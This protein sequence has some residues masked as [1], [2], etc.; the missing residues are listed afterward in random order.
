MIFA[1]GFAA[2]FALLQVRWGVDFARARA[3]A[4]DPP[5]PCACDVR[6]RCTCRW[7]TSWRTLS[8][9]SIPT[10]LHHARRAAR[11][12][13][14]SCADKHLCT[15]NTYT[16]PGPCWRRGG[17]ASVCYPPVTLLPLAPLCSQD[18]RGSSAHRPIWYAA[19]ETQ[20]R[21]CGAQGTRLHTRVRVCVRACER[22]CVRV[23]VRT[24]EQAS[25]RA[26]MHAWSVGHSVGR[27]TLQPSTINLNPKF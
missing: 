1:L 18:W 5:A 19:S 6:R 4:E 7:A 26:C 2:C 21:A 13:S 12:V 8:Y 14:A 25:E 10:S 16:H 27:V 17:A 11:C 23:H 20:M 15:H 9:S 3:H 22:A 24:C